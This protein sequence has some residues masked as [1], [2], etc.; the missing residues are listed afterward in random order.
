MTNQWMSLASNS[1]MT[2]TTSEQNM[3]AMSVRSTNALPFSMALVA[4][5][6]LGRARLAAPNAACEYMLFQI[7]K[8]RS[9]RLEAAAAG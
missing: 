7:R 1:T 6:R 9:V 2:M 3:K 8:K 5:C 4:R